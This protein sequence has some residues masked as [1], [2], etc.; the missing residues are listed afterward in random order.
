MCHNTIPKDGLRNQW[1][2]RK[3]ESR[4]KFMFLLAG[5][6]AFI[7]VTK[8]VFFFYSHPWVIF[9]LKKTGTLCVQFVFRDTYCKWER[10]GCVDS[11]LKDPMLNPL[12]DYCYM[13][14]QLKMCKSETV[15]KK[16]YI[17]FYVNYR[18]LLTV[19]LNLLWF[20]KAATLSMHLTK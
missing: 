7:V 10:T 17:S 9:L 1:K 14:F 11:P 20:I 16:I 12:G 5:T 18:K 19:P 4:E 2:G 15:G 8:L 6:A 3:I 13:P